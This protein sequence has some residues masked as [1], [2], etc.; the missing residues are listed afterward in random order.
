MTF[1]ETPRSPKQPPS[2][3]SSLS[4]PPPP[5]A[6]RRRLA[7]EDFGVLPSFLP[8][9]RS[10]LRPGNNHIR[11]TQKPFDLRPTKSPHHM[12]IRPPLLRQHHRHDSNITVAN[13]IIITAVASTS[14]AAAPHH[15]QQ[16]AGGQRLNHDT[17][18]GRPTVPSHI[19][20]N[21]PPPPLCAVIPNKVKHESFTRTMPVQIQKTEEELPQTKNFIAKS[22]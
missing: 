5:P 11:H 9:S 19:W 21:L 18:S 7:I 20:K 6:K 8:C 2:T 22:A 13:S 12:N 15:H 17:P 14:P 1:C 4:P 16:P 3:S 10:V